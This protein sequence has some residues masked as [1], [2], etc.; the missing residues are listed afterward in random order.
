MIPLTREEID[1][2]KLI[3]VQGQFVEADALRVAESIREYDPNLTLQVCET[4]RVGDPPF[5]VMERCRDGIQ[6]VAMTAW[7]LDGEILDRIKAA[8]TT[9]RNV[10]ES[11]LK[12]NE[13]IRNED[14][15]RYQEAQNELHLLAS[16]VLKSPK[17]TYTA[18]HPLTGEKLTFKA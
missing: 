1:R 8:D 15:R 5:R 2:L 7:K 17:D 16:D 4:G 18:R 3:E 6:R 12:D 13:N 10:S 14:R 9:H 11:I